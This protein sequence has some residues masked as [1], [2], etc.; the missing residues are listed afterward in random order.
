MTSSGSRHEVSIGRQKPFTRWWWY[1][2]S[3]RNDQISEQL[4]WAA[5]HGFGGVEIAW[6][7]PS[8]PDSQPEP[9]LSPAWSALVHH[10][11]KE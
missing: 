4:E 1:A 9:F 11:W 3:I 2:D 8:S 6:V 5:L 7:Y 10:A